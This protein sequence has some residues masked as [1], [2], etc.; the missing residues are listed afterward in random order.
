VRRPPFVWSF[1][2]ESLTNVRPATIC[3]PGLQVFQCAGCSLRVPPISRTARFS[4]SVPAQRPDLW[5]NQAS[6][7]AS[8]HG[9]R[10]LSTIPAESGNN[11]RGAR[12]QECVRSRSHAHPGHG[13]SQSGSLLDPAKQWPEP[14]ERR[15]DCCMTGHQGHCLA[16]YTEKSMYSSPDEQ[17]RKSPGVFSLSIIL[18]CMQRVPDSGNRPFGTSLCTEISWSAHP[19]REG[20]GTERG[21]PF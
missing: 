15:P 5:P 3:L 10:Y 19:A 2:N 16:L 17:S 12:L 11:A 7:L 9:T 21:C 6:A 1:F 14:P 13:N 4:S 8:G 20:T 18:N